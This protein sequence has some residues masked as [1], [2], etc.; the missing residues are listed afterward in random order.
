MPTNIITAIHR[1]GLTGLPVVQDFGGHFHIISEWKTVIPP[2]IENRVYIQTLSHGQFPGTSDFY[3]IPN[4]LTGEPD[5]KYIT[6]AGKT[7]NIFF[8]MASQDKLRRELRGRE[9]SLIGVY[10]NG[11]FVMSIPFRYD[12]HYVLAETLRFPAGAEI[13]LRVRPCSRRTRVGILAGG[14]LMEDNL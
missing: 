3:S 12:I 14:Y 4:E 8:I 1:N 9:M 6:P 11:T 13:E 7:L 2:S 10:M 5:T